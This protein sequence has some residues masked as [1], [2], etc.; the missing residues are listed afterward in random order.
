[1]IPADPQRLK[2]LARSVSAEDGHF[3]FQA[4]PPGEYRLFAWEDADINQ[5][6]YDAE[7]RKPFESRGET[8]DLAAKQK[9]TALLRRSAGNSS[10]TGLMA[11][12]KRP[13]RVGTRQAGVPASH[14]T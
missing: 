2:T 10:S 1:L 4:V 11:T 9:A 6:L 13:P 14:P 8:V 3:S 7:F 5:A 12:K